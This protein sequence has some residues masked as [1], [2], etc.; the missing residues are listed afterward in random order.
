MSDYDEGFDQDYA[1][2]YDEFNSP[3]R[4]DD[5]NVFEERQLDLD[6]D[7]GEYDPDYDEEVCEVCGDPEC[8]GGEG[9]RQACPTRRTGRED[10][11]LEADVHS[12]EFP[13]LDS[14][15]FMTRMWSVEPVI[16]AGYDADRSGWVS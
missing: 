15:E 3:E 16:F 11:A 13:L 9:G 7:A 4:D 6:R 12:R 14:V 10:D 2:D 1:E 5:Y 8:P